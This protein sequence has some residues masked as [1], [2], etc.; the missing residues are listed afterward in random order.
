MTE[1]KIIGWHHP[2]NGYAFE[3]A[4]GD[5]KGQG[6]LA[7]CMQSMGS[8]RV[9]HDSATE[10]TEDLLHLL[11]DLHLGTSVGT[12]LLSD[13]KDVAKASSLSMTFIIVF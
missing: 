11:L 3:Q 1:D 13:H 9:G 5:G 12:L 6:S 10:L 8:Q 2:L 4:P 7:C